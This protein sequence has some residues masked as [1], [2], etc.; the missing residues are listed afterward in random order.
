MLQQVP[1]RA[2]HVM[3]KPSGSDCNLNCDYCFYLEKQSLYRE[4]PVTHMDDDTLEAYIRHYIAASEL[5]NEVAFTW[6]GGEP[7]LL[8][9]EFYRRAVALQAKY[10]A[11]RKISNSFQTNGVL[12]DDE[13]CAFLAENNFLV[14]LSL[15]GPAEIHNQYRVTKGG[16]PTHKLVM[17]AL[18]LLQK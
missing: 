9:L 11:G 12:L 2:F 6:Q 3:A 13:W 4:K 1:T 8:G 18:T 14:G 16:R 15:D 10:G 5:Q 7:T 17:R